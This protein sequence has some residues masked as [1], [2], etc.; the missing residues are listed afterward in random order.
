[1][2]NA[3]EHREIHRGRCTKCDH[4]VTFTINSTSGEVRVEADT[5]P[6]MWGMY[7]DQQQ[8]ANERANKLYGIETTG[9]ATLKG[10]T[11]DPGAKPLTIKT[12]LDAVEKASRRSW[13]P[14]TLSPV[15]PPCPN[16]SGP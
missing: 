7:F 15:A 13:V 4:K 5:R 16:E 11:I 2:R 1:K 10:A 12:I 14:A 9:G 6:E 3:C 8:S